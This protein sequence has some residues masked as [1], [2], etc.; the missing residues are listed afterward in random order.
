MNT[1][2]NIIEN[3]DKL[4]FYAHRNNMN[5]DE[6]IAYIIS[7]YEQKDP[8]AKDLYKFYKGGER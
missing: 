3:N 6:F 8:N 1:I 5:M 4:K 7:L 2:N